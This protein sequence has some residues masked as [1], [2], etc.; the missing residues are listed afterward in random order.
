MSDGTLSGAASA[1]DQERVIRHKWPDR[2][3][4]WVLA[5]SVLT[6]IGTS[7]LPILGLKF[8]WVTIHWIAG[9]VLTVAVLY[10]IVRRGLL[11]REL[12]WMMIWP[13]DIRNAWRACRQFFLLPGPAPGKPGKYPLLQSG[14]HHLVATV[15]LVTIGTG[16]LM[17]RKVDTPLW[18]RD[19]YWSPKDFWAGMDFWSSAADFWATIYILHGFAT[20]ALVALVMMHIY[21]A[22]IPQK[23]WITR[24]MLLGWVTRR[25]YLDHHDPSRWV[26][27]SQSAADGPSTFSA[28]PAGNA[29]SKTKAA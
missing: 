9:L 26:V 24:S 20:I 5:I 10:H 21:I 1:G 16:L 25:D 15:I 12:K 11:W 22:V 7:L 4:H 19:P 28:N 29:S 14:Y 3:Y 8:P 13:R 27:D 17:T 6:L 23:F 2:I 18:E